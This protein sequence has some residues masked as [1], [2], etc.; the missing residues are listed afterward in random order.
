M[1][2][3][4]KLVLIALVTLPVGIL[5]F[6]LALFDRK[7]KLAY[8]ISRCWTWAVLRIGGIRLRVEGLERLDSKR[9]Y[10]F[11][12]NHRS[13]IDIPVLIQALPRFQL[14]WLA[15]KELLYVPFFGLALWASR[16]IIVERSNL[17]KAMASLR[18]AREKIGSGISVVIFPEGTR[19][20]RGELLPFK[21]G[22]FVLA[23]QSRTPIVPVTINGT[24]AVLPKGDWRIRGGDVE[25]IVSEAV[26][27]EPYRLANLEQLVNRVRGDMECHYRRPMGSS[28]EESACLRA[29]LPTE[30]LAEK[31]GD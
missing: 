14:R 6:S 20:S 31:Q 25:I 15:K 16:H 30:S 13:N 7:G 23:L 17:S 5:I 21:R 19:S 22:G 27:V 24:E 2:Y 10:I 1:R 26:P 4:L 3:G 12:A 8:A 11:M 18:K 9:P 28:T 29:E